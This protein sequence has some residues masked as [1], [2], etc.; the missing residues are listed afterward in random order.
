MINVPI[1]ETVAFQI[2]AMVGVSAYKKQ[3]VDE[4]VTPYQVTI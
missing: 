3:L 4:G 2:Y 1:W